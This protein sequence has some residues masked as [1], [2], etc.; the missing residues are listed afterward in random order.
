MKKNDRADCLFTNHRLDD[1]G[2]CA[3]CLR[4]LARLIN[5]LALIAAS[6]TRKR[7]VK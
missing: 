5:R 6:R 4:K 2:N 1:L 7:T 3:A